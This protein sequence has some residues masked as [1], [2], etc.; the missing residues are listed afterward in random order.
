MPVRIIDRLKVIDVEHDEGER[1]ARIPCDLREITHRGR[2]SVAVVDARERVDLHALFDFN[3]LLLEL[4]GMLQELAL[5]LGT[6]KDELD[7]EEADGVD[8]ER[9]EEALPFV[10]TVLERER[11]D[12]AERHDDEQGNQ[13][14]CG[15][16]VACLARLPECVCDVAAPDGESRHV[17]ELHHIETELPHHLYDDADHEEHDENVVQPHDPRA[18][19]TVHD[20]DEEDAARNGQQV[21]RD[22]LRAPPQ[23]RP[24]HPHEDEVRGAEHPDKERRQEEHETQIDT[25][26]RRIDDKVNADHHHEDD[27]GRHPRNI[28]KVIDKNPLDKFG[29]LIDMHA[30]ELREHP[31]IVRCH[32][33]DE[34]PSCRPCGQIDEMPLA[35]VLLQLRVT[36]PIAI[37]GR[38]IQID[39]DGLIN[40]RE[41]E[42]LI[43]PYIRRD[44]DAQPCVSR[45]LGNSGTLTRVKRH[46]RSIAW[47]EVGLCFHRLDVGIDGILLPVFPRQRFL[48][49]RHTAPD[50]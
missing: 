43:T 24:I 29:F 8:A 34:L 9:C 44:M 42:A 47:S 30:V 14:R 6:I 36:D 19:L 17:G 37:D 50:A 1:L 13:E 12:D 22:Q 20:L 4:R 16:L 23:N 21:G 5:R 15:V 32:A 40:G 11:I 49:C 18:V 39:T 3:N 41:E 26:P 28:R 10:E 46:P 48:L 31:W 33:D 35:P 38:S 7:D 25:A 45:S 2:E 27:D